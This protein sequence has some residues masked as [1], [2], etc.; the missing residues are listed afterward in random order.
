VC[1]S[2]KKHRVPSPSR[3]PYRYYASPSQI[4]PLG[5]RESVRLSR[6]SKP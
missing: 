5:T 2:S 1:P 6:S 4:H 3:W